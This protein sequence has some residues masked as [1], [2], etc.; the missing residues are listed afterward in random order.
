MM[1]DPGSL[2]QDDQ[3]HKVSLDLDLTALT[4]QQKKV[5]TDRERA[6]FVG[7]YEFQAHMIVTE[8]LFPM[9]KWES[10]ARPP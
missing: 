6:I 4:N 8:V 2:I 7:C 3:S 5:V 10:R 9:V 1:D